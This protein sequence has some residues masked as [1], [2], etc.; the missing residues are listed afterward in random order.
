ML[1]RPTWKAS[2]SSISKFGDGQFR[3]YLDAAHRASSLYGSA[4]SCGIATS[5]RA[6]ASAQ[7]TS[8]NLRCRSRFEWCTWKRFQIPKSYSKPDET[9]A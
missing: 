6:T 3:R 1:R 2:T 7:E 9:S 5:L 8:F 4:A